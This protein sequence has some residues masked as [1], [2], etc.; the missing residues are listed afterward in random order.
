MRSTSAEPPSTRFANISLNATRFR[1][2]SRTCRTYLPGSRSTDHVPSQ[3]S[4]PPFVADP[5]G[6]ARDVSERKNPKIA[7]IGPRLAAEIYGLEIL[8]ENVEDADHNTTRM[9]IM[10]R[11]PM[12]PDVNSVKCITTIIFK[13]RSVPAALYKALGGFATNGINLT[14]LESYMIGWS[15]AAAQFYV[16]ADG[17]PDEPAMKLALEELQFFCPEGAVQVLGTY[18]SHA[19]RENNISTAIA[20]S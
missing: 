9:L 18:H 5:A 12:I 11:E 14:K 13:V 17:H 2:A 10:G 3:D 1:D 4:P 20:S 16:D 7:A 19:F 15:F 6:A 8:R